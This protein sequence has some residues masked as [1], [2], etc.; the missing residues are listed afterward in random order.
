MSAPTYGTAYVADELDKLGHH[1][2]ATV[3]RNLLAVS[4]DTTFIAQARTPREVLDAVRPLTGYEGAIAVVHRFADS[5]QPPEDTDE[6][7]H[8]LSSPAN[9]ESLRRSIADLRSAASRDEPTDAEETAYRAGWDAAFDY[10]GITEDQLTHAEAAHVPVI[11]VHMMYGPHR[12][13]VQTQVST[14]AFANEDEAWA[15]LVIALAALKE[16][17]YR[18][19][20]TNA[21]NARVAAIATEADMA[22]SQIQQV[23]DAAEKLSY[24][25][26]LPD[27]TP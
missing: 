13:V 24:L 1:T 22:T 11:D 7:A 14:R 9:A 17:R 19:S 21:R 4:A 16:F 27:V 5:W 15:H 25:A 23:L 3:L 26:P 8:L 18:E 2:S 10:L 12:V 20:V 6:T